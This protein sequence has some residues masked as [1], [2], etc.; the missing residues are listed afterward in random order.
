MKRPSRKK[1][2]AL[3][4]LALVVWLCWYP[5]R[6]RMLFLALPHETAIAVRTAGLASEYKA[7]AANPT[8]IGV[9]AR[10]GMSESDIERFQKNAVGV[11]WTLFGL[12]GADSVVGYVPS[13][14]EPTSWEMLPGYLAGASYTGWRAKPIEFL[15][16]IKWAP[17]I[18]KLSVSE[19]GVRFLDFGYEPGFENFRYLGLD[20]VDGVLLATYSDDPDDVLALVERVRTCGP[21]DP[22]PPVFGSGESNPP[23]WQGAHL[24]THQLWI[25][26][27]L[28]APVLPFDIGADLPPFGGTV[29]SFK[30]ENLRA[31]VERIK[32]HD[33]AFRGAKTFAEMREIATP[34]ADI[35]SDAA[36]IGMVAGDASLLTDIFA[37]TSRQEGIFAT[38]VAAKP[39]EGRVL[40]IAVPSINGGVTFA[41]PNDAAVF[42]A[43]VAA[44]LKSISKSIGGLLSTAVSR[45]DRTLAF[46]T[47]DASL[48]KQRASATKETL[49]AKIG[50][51]RSAHPDAALVAEI[52]LDA[53]WS[54]V[55][56]INA[57][58]KLAS[59]FVKSDEL[60]EIA[61]FAA[62]A[63]EIQA[64]IPSEGRITAVVK[65]AESGGF[66][67][68]AQ[69]VFG[70]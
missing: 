49:S 45:D 3:F 6:A 50:S 28:L 35:P 56:Q 26:P 15:W 21:R 23:P 7:F 31:S 44:T 38:Y 65:R 36:R 18:G 47:D 19:N 24:A 67:A 22:A 30:N 55:K 8:I 10:A 11:F 48:K 13:G 27:S 34:C 33:G 5:K 61:E 14:A 42:H 32:L 29:G 2:T 41:D 16:R 58:V 1:L 70:R 52:D 17:G 51:W 25:S 66:E 4:A 69:A 9:F 12:T 40:G 60:Y 20:I 37:L 68:Q 39:Y 63:S 43:A 59:R 53:L 54:E 46:G 57:L 62:I 64:I